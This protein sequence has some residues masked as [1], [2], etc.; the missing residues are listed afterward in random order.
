M[1]LYKLTDLLT[2]N[3]GKVWTGEQAPKSKL[4][5]LDTGV[6][7]EKIA[8]KA[9][10]RHFGKAF[11]FLNEGKA[12]AAADIGNKTIV[13]EI[14]TGVSSNNKTAQHWRSTIGEPG[15]AEKVQLVGMSDGAKN[16]HNQAKDKEILKRK[17]NL[18]SRTRSRDSSSVKSYTVG[19][20]LSPGG[21]RGDVFLIPGFH[22][23][24]GWNKYATNE[25]YIGT[26][27]K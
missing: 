1:T 23:R 25:Y 27:K 21:S 18:L 19:I 16:R 4:S 10:T 9:L 2:R 22:L 26:Y 17:R 15:K 12:N 11:E 14:K 6:L 24:L 20:I 8:K 13:V 3:K 5:K 7:G